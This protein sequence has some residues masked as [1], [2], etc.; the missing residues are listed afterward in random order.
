MVGLPLIA[1]IPSQLPLAFLITAGTF[2]S[3]YCADWLRRYLLSRRTA[4]LTGGTR[5][6]R[7]GR[8]G[9]YVH[10]S[11]VAHASFDAKPMNMERH[12]PAQSSWRRHQHSINECCLQCFV[13]CLYMSQ[14]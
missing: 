2:G 5:Q 3:L 7:D 6:P 8:T 14:F 1:A 4:R 11:S 10:A 13:F 12:A 9:I